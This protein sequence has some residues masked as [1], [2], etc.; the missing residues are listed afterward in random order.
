M[1]TKW[2]MLP[3][4]ILALAVAASAADISGTWKGTAQTP[5]GSV[6]RTF[7]F[8]VDGNKLT[9]D[10]TSDMF[11]KSTIEDGKIEGD[12]VTFTITVDF[13]GNQGKVNYTGKIKGDDEIDFSVEIPAYDQ[14]VEY[15]A[16]RV[17]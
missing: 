9:G 4:A 11:G 16:K 5:N 14:K 12:T 7:N 10:T 13:Q 1:T 2:T 17:K 8:K 15:V 6:E 3:L